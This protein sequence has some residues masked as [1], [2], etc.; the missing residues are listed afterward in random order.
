MVFLQ[1][2]HS[3]GD[4]ENW[5][6]R[7]WRNRD[8]VFFS[9][10]EHNARGTL[11]AIRES[12][13][14]EIEDKAIDKQCRYVILKC[15]IQDS[16]FLLVSLCNSNNEA[17]QLKTMEKVRHIIEN[18]DPIFNY[19]LVLG[20]DMNFIQDTLYDSDG[21]TPTL[22]HSSIAELRYLQSWRDL[23]DIWCIRNPSVKRF[24]Y[25]Q[26]KPL[27]QEGLTTF[28]YQI[29]YRTIPNRHHTSCSD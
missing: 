20:G 14:F 1:E 26:H 2:T 19:N 15:L 27:I 16:P 29:T 5:W 3:T 24:T 21:G 9:H 23:V 11:I 12:I 22:K 6:S 18:L 13:S 28:S 10:G 25:R 7:Q 8:L 17:E 4:T